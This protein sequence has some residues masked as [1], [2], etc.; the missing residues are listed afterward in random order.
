MTKH[1][2][3][4]NLL[5]NTGGTDEIDHGAHGPKCLLGPFGAHGS[6]VP[7]RVL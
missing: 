6:Q 4:V 1:I 2:F 5:T 3:C 7:F